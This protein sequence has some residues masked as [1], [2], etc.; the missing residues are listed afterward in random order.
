MFN[1]IFDKLKYITDN[2]PAEDIAN[3]I[4]T[5]LNTVIDKIA[6]EENGKKLS[7]FF[8]KLLNTLFDVAQK[9]NWEG[10]GEGIGNFL[11]EIDWGT[12]FQ[13]V[14]GIIK[15]VVS[16]LISGFASTTAGDMAI[17]LTTAIGGIS[18]A[19]AAFPLVD[20]LVQGFTGSSVGS[21][22]ITGIKTLFAPVTGL[23][24]P[25]GAIYEAF[26]M[27]AI[28]L[29]VALESLTGL[30]VPVGA[31][32]GIIAA[33]IAGV[34]AVVVDLWN[35]SESFRDTVIDAF[36]KVKDSL[37]DAFTKVK[38]AIAPLWEAIKNLGASLYDFYKNSGLKG[39][40]D[41][42]AQLLV[43]I[44]GEVLST[45]ITVLADVFS[46]LAGVL[47]GLAEIATGILEFFNGLFSLDFERMAEG[48][49]LVGQGIKDGFI[50]LVEGMFDIGF[51][52]I[53][54]LL[55]GIWEA[56]KDIGKWLD[57]Y[58]V[59]PFI[60]NFKKLFGIHSPS[61]V[62]EEQGGFIMDGLFNGIS[63]LVDHVASPFIDL[64]DKIVE[65]CRELKEKA[66]NRFEELKTNIKTS[67]DNTGRNIE[68]GWNSIREKF[69]QFDNFLSGVFSTDWSNSFGGF[70]NI[71]NG[72][73]GTV[74]NIW[75]NIKG[76]FRGVTDFVAGVFTGDWRRAWESVKTI[77]GNIWDGFANIVKAP[78]NAVIGFLNGLI[79][80]VES[81]VNSVA[82]MLNGLKINAPGWVTKLT[83]IT[84]IGFN[85]P[86]WTAGRIPYLARGGLVTS[87]TL[88]VTGENFK[89]EAV[90]PLENPRSMRMIAESIMA[91]APAV[92]M[93]EEI[94][95]NAVARGMSM[96]MMNNI[97]NLSGN[98]PKYIQNS[99]SLDGD[100]L[101][102]AVT[103]AQDDRDF[104]YNMA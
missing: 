99:I 14:F 41:L 45:A 6:W 93:D 17:K 44:G 29:S 32:M 65:K 97:G 38:E 33:A 15:E 10:L 86:T 88:A 8:L 69:Q 21:H 58:V 35:T 75:E 85:L 30:S 56:V 82:K 52:I 64:K 19:K 74:S 5:W 101:L 98:S 95:T 48:I 81:A 83:G 47:T 42:F 53:G 59:T 43:S 24:A 31:S 73:F 61:T 94:L 34:I 7:D 36:T 67:M 76:I 1:G 4:S 22:L 20:S 49:T 102:R 92:G 2:F 9:V 77:F 18:L 40:V 68:T 66:S 60:D 104:R 39:I 12:I 28:N 63:E 78:I 91:E 79:G 90:L 37:V 26:G 72:F 46:T 70:G 84:S 27:G 62:M 25:G 51:D 100:V 16:G 55:S 71:M 96:A 103:K 3:G 89:K 57:E 54:G 11:S 13:K 23:F 87:P 50:A 80:G